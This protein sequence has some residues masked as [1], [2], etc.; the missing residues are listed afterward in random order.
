MKIIKKFFKNLNLISKLRWCRCKEIIVYLFKDI[1]IR[2]PSANNSF[3]LGK[4]LF[5][6]NKYN[7]FIIN[8]YYVLVK[9]KYV[10]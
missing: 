10:F 5:D 2:F 1:E 7:A 6:F 9:I 8:T 4:C 3:R